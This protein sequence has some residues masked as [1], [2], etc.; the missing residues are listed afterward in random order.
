MTNQAG[1]RRRRRRLAAA[2]AFGALLLVL[3]VIGVLL[4]RAMDERRRAEAARLVALGR[5]ELD[6][7]PTATLAYARRSLEVADT[8]PARALAVEALWRSPSARILPVA[9]GGANGMTFSWDGSALAV[10]T[11]SENVLVVS[12]KDGTVRTLGGFP[13]PSYPTSPAFS[14]D[15]KLLA[16]FVDAGNYVRLSSVE[17]GREIRRLSPELLGQDSKPAGWLNWLASREGIAL[18]WRESP[19]PTA[20]VKALLWPWDASGV[21]SLLYPRWPASKGVVEQGAADPELRLEAHARGGRVFVRPFLGTPTRPSARSRPTSRV[22]LPTCGSARAATASRSAMRKAP[23]TVFDLRPPVPTRRWV[24]RQ[25]Q[26]SRPTAGSTR[27][28]HASPGA[29]RRTERPPW[30]TSTVRPTPEPLSLRRSDVT[31]T[32]G[33]RFDPRASWLT[34]LNDNSLTFWQVGQPWARVIHGHSDSV[35]QLVFTQDSRWLVSCSKDRIRR[36]PL[37]PKA[38][39]AGVVANLSGFDACYG[40]AVAPD[41]REVV[42]GYGGVQLVPFHEGGGRWLLKEKWPT[43]ATHEAVAIDASGRWVAAAAG[44]SRPG[45][46]K[47]LRVWERSSDVP[48]HDWPLEVPGVPETTMGQAAHRVAFLDERRLLVAGSSGVRRFDVETG[49]SEWLWRIDRAIWADLAVSASGKLVAATGFS[50][51]EANDQWVDPVV[52]D[53][54]TGSRRE[55]RSHG[56]RVLSVALDASGKVLVTGANDGVVRVGRPDGSEPHLLFGH[57]VPAVTVAV[58]PDGRWVASA[59]GSEIRLWPMPDIAGPR[60][61]RCRTVS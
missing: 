11:Y 50:G 54:A 9:D 41:G 16:T 17:D 14:P 38:G 45:T 8:V 49:A 19:A 57:G 47:R 53:L 20:E 52:L 43:D 37:A 61:T 39:E 46:S 2:A 42:R 30:R 22:R 33:V 23:L 48:K 5:V 24:G 25:P 60:C 13:A 18:F 58:S 1:R 21:R 12:R 15:G 28:A 6:R 31:G 10:Q 44:F 29:R 3:A 27:R 32:M 4:R 59:A 36:W 40:V 56:A 51:P 55:I 34:A 35:S 26:P 7:Y